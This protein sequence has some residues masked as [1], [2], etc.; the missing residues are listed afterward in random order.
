MVR[1]KVSFTHKRQQ[2]N[3]KQCVHT[4]NRT[5]PSIRHWKI[6]RHP[7]FKTTYLYVCI[8]FLSFIPLPFFNWLLAQPPIYVCVC[9]SRDRLENI[10]SAKTNKCKK[11]TN[12]QK[13]SNSPGSE[14]LLVFFLQTEKTL[15]LKW[16]LTG[17]EFVQLPGLVATTTQTTQPFPATTGVPDFQS[18]LNFSRDCSMITE[19]KKNSWTRGRKI[20]EGVKWMVCP[21]GLSNWLVHLW[22]QRAL[23]GEFNIRKICW[24]FLQPWSVT[25]WLSP[26]G[27]GSD[28]TPTT[29]S[30]PC[31]EIV[32]T[33]YSKTSITR[34]Q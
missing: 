23:L 13:L 11:Q 30:H 16:P 29:Q 33:V 20:V 5:W 28:S 10:L 18:F 25:E 4:Q 15:V 24:F 19:K 32:I 12:K 21:A 1:W 22:C 3:F 27:S 17:L 31:P 8:V 2:H 9:V 6:N 14:V 26:F 7:C 34:G